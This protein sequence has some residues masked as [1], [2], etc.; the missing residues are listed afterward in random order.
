MNPAETD[1]GPLAPYFYFLHGKSIEVVVVSFP[2]R[3]TVVVL[4]WRFL[5]VGS[6]LGDKAARHRI[7]PHGYMPIFMSKYL[8]NFTSDDPISR[9]A[10]R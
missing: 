10:A 1:V 3:C 7:M 6:R 5:V 4:P 9:S 2:P 8:V